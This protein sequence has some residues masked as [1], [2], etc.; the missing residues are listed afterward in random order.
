[1][2]LLKQLQLLSNFL[3]NS[4]V[5]QS[6]VSVKLALHFVDQ[7]QLF[8]LPGRQA[9]GSNR[10][11]LVTFPGST[12]YRLQLQS[13]GCGAKIATNADD[14]PAYRFPEGEKEM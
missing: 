13:P 1:M 7:R 2:I 4:E 3:P 12:G 10:S 14:F 5:P 8:S 11:A 6:K 9:A